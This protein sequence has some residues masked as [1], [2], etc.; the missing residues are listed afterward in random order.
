MVIRADRRLRLEKEDVLPGEECSLHI[1]LHNGKARVFGPAS[2][3]SLL[4]L[5][6]PFESFKCDRLLEEPRISLRSADG[7]LEEMF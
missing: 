2:H 1:D 6:N 3:A 5:G 7:S 4:P